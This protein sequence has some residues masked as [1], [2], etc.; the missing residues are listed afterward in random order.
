MLQGVTEEMVFYCR[1]D[2]EYSQRHP[3]ESMGK[4]SWEEQE[5]EQR[6]GDQEPRVEEENTWL[7]WQV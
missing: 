5:G 7:K 1:C 2:G 6:T 4:E 3:E